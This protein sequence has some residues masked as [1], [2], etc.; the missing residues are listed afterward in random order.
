[1]ALLDVVF[2]LLN[3]AGDDFIEAR[4][5]DGHGSSVA[6]PTHVTL[7]G[8]QQV[9]VQGEVEVKNTVG[10]ELAVTDVQ[11]VDVIA[12]L[13]KI[14]QNTDTLE[15]SADSIALNADQIQLNT[16]EVEAKLQTLIDGQLP[17]NHQVSVSNF[18]AIQE[19]SGT[20]S[21]NQPVEVTGTQLDALTDA[22][23]RA[24]AVVVSDDYQTGE[25]LPDQTGANNVLTF[26]F[27]SPVQNV[28]V[29]AIDVTDP[30]LSGEVRVDP[31]GGT[32]SANLGIPVSYGGGFPIPFTGDTVRIFAPANAR[33]TIY[34]N[35][36]A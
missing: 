1:M 8:S 14:D 31:F 20:V 7:D 29:Y 5:E 36:R 2:R 15:L 18:P 9:V 33:V 35:R 4:R 19:V 11:L 6:N 22:E 17:D 30:T 12:L 28:W 24:S 23:L 21:V 34:G 32:P 13:N 26:T 16:D 27:A 3:K 25:I 10:A